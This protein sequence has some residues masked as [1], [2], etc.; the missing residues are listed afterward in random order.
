MSNIS[1]R[2]RHIIYNYST[3]DTTKI[4]LEGEKRYF[5]NILSGITH[6]CYVLGDGVTQVSALSF[7]G[8]VHI[9]TNININLSV[10]AIQGNRVCIVNTK[11][12]S[13]T[14][15]AGAYTRTLYRNEIIEFRYNGSEWREL[16]RNDGVPPGTILAW[17]ESKKTVDL[18][19]NW[20]RCNGQT[21]N[22]PES[23]YH[24]EVI[25]NLNGFAGGA[26]SPDLSRKAQMF[27][28][29]GT[30]SGNGQED[31][32]QRITG[33][34][35]KI[36]MTTGSVNDGVFSG[37][38]KNSDSNRPTGTAEDTWNIE[39]DNANSIFPNTAK[40][41]DEEN[42]SVNMSVVFIMKIK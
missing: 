37:S 31:A 40:T 23:R 5:D 29:G 22:D 17:H 18:P 38:S 14:I 2:S 10:L 11:N 7:I 8:I 16:Y 1:A 15:T 3:Y 12:G 4:P 39:F 19:D 36:W 41:D 6:P 32:M 9:E 42:R 13:I 28:R 27:L 25:E 26:N 21:L 33:N 35:S 20:V 30:T 24:G 34:A